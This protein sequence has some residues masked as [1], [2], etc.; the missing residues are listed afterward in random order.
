M[1][2]LSNADTTRDNV[3]IST[4]LVY[5]HAIKF[6]IKVNIEH[7]CVCVSVWVAE[8]CI[9]LLQQR[10]RRALGNM[11]T[12]CIFFLLSLRIPNL[13]VFALRIVHSCM[14]SGIQQYSQLACVRVAFQVD[15]L[16]SLALLLVSTV[17]SLGTLS[18]R[19]DHR[20]KTKK[21]VEI[22]REKK[23]ENVKSYSTHAYFT[24]C[25]LKYSP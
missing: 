1:P 23:N 5:I 10:C 16:L 17:I 4:A 14:A 3:A 24:H 6:P 2:T 8:W 21:I 12:Q 25:R 9:L 15:R 18:R 11:H 20:R 13:C 19:D 7:E 22:E